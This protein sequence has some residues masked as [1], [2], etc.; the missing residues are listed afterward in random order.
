[1]LEIRYVWEF[2]VR[3]THWVTA[4]SIL[5]LSLTGF[6]IG[7][8]FFPGGDGA[9]VMGWVRFVHFVAAYVFLMSFII[10]SIWF[11]IGNEYGSWRMFFPWAT[12]KGRANALSFFRYYTFTGK[13]IPYEVGHNALA[14]LAYAVIFFLYLVMIVSGFT[15]YGMYQ[16]G[17]FW[18]GMLGWLL[19]PIDSQ[20]LRLT[21]HLGM[22]LIIGFVINHIYSAWLMDVK[23]MNGTVSSMFSGYKYIN[24]K[25]L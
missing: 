19:V 20:W 11:L 17:G 21:H 24:P 14:C 9:Y 22:W 18:D 25:D 13:K 2:P 12:Q 15:L 6:Y 3:L 23:E 7:N 1:M 4:V 16:P 5:V 10:R 8:P